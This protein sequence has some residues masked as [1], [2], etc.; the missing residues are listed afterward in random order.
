V[1]P[2]DGGKGGAVA[3]N[4]AFVNHTR[5]LLSKRVN[6]ALAAIAASCRSGPA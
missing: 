6:A 5:L 4:K 2:P 1:S 3:R